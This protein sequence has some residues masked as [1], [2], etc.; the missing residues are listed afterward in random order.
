MSLVY[1]P[2]KGMRVWVNKKGALIVRLHYTADPAKAVPSWGENMRK[3]MD[4]A[5]WA[6]EFQIDFGATAGA[7]LY[8]MT[9]EY[10]LEDE[11]NVPESWTRYYALDPRS[12][13]H[14]SE[15]Q[16]LR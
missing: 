13:E 7:Q 1:E 12:E 5:Y 4:S 10:T 15:L 8:H 9:D 6:Q 3:G 2:L 14:T 16:S 11:F